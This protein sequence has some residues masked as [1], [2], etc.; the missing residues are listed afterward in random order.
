ML[1]TS[2]ETLIA[3]R[4]LVRDMPDRS[5]IV[6][7]LKISQ[8]GGNAHAHFSATA[9]IWDAHGTWSG[10]AC[11]RNGRDI[12]AGGCCHG[13][14]LEAFPGAASFV[15]M[16]LSDFPSGTPM[17]AEANGFY[18]LTAKNADYNDRN[19]YW[20][21]SSGLESLR[22]TWRLDDVRDMPYELRRSFQDGG[23]TEDDR[24]AFRAFYE[25]QLP[26]WA[27]EARAARDMLELMPDAIDLRG[28]DMSGEPCERRPLP[29]WLIGADEEY[30]NV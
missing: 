8:L 21:V 12:D 7:T 5:R 18:Y 17:H 28:Y 11:A 19:G 16:H 2:K 26:R 30:V 22:H 24:S 9:S 14:I 29:S 23:L 4:V 13:T 15:R 25:S 6:A 1:A 20:W 3:Q 10:A 27:A